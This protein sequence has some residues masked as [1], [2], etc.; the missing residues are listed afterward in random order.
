MKGLLLTLFTGLVLFMLFSVLEY[1]IY[2]PSNIRKLLF[3]G[4]LIFTGLLFLQF[5]GVPL[6]KLTRVLKPIDI[7]KSSEIIQTHFSEI[8]DKLLNIIELAYLNEN[9]YSSEIIEASINQKINDI[10]WYNFSD[11]VQFKNLKYVSISFIISILS[12]FGIS[13]YNKNILKDSSQRIIH[14]NKQFVQPA[15]FNFVLLNTDL[16]VKKGDSFLISAQCKG[17]EIPQIVY[18]NIEGNN[19]LMR[20]VKPGFFEFEINSVINPFHFYFSDLQFQSKSYFLT[21]LPKPGIT[22]F[23]VKTIPPSYTNL[24]SEILQNIGD[25]QVPH[26]TKILWEFTGIDM[27]SL[28]II[29]NDSNL[30]SADNIN[31]LFVAE[32]TFYKSGNYNV[33]IKNSSTEYEL[34]LSYSIDVIPD[35]FP[36]IQVSQLIDSTKLTRFFFRGLIGDDYG[37]SNLA[38]HFNINN[39]DSAIHIPFVRNLNDQDFYFSFDFANL[40]LNSGIISYY[41]TVSDNDIINGFKTTSSDNFIFTIPNKNEILASEKEQFNKLQNMLNKSSEMANEIKKD[42]DNLRLKNMDTNISDWEKIANGK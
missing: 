30:V 22:F 27:D 15:P 13:I 7:T 33:F 41:F 18:V 35:L 2:L 34:A 19:Y 39:T 10:K 26:G 9:K 12:V 8:K 42:L 1:S 11:A 38:F 40:E 32:K 17:E 29:V 6:L 16:K 37:F 14:Y 31:D 5:V 3:F 28:F 21:M 24:S 20:N 36:E 25:I 23:T 4:Y